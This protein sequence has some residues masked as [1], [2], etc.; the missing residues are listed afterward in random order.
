METIDAPAQQKCVIDTPSASFKFERNAT[1]HN[2][3]P[4]GSQSLTAEAHAIVRIGCVRAS[5]PSS[6]R[7]SSATFGHGRLPHALSAAIVIGP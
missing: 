4:Q 1:S 3:Q 6:S 7:T 5:T 2:H